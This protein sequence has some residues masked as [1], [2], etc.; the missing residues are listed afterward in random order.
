[1]ALALVVCAPGATAQIAI[2]QIQVLEGD[3]AVHAA[4]SRSQRP[5]TVQITDEMGR[6]VQGAAVSFRLPED[7]SAQFLNGMKTDVQVTGLDGRVSVWGIQWG[8]TPGPQ[9]IRLTAAKDQARAGAIVAQ[10]VT[11]SPVAAGAESSPVSRL[12]PSGPG[13][14]KWKVLGLVAAGAAVGGLAVVLSRKP[15]GTAAG[16]AITVQVGQPTISITRP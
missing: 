16:P 15:A 9:R 2:L 5:I 11:D 6:P 1:M 3:G 13:R 4:G 10:Y 7:D 8:R 14:G 12:S